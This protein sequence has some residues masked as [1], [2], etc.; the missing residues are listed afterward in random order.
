MIAAPSESQILYSSEEKQNDV[1]EVGPGNLK[2][3]YNAKGKLI[4][5]TNSRTK[6]CSMVLLHFSVLFTEFSNNI[7]VLCILC[8]CLPLCV[9]IA[10]LFCFVLL[11]LNA[12]FN[13]PVYCILISHI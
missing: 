5:Y 1:I 6:V 3:V 2:L 9:Y 13:G 4:R 11:F 10:V 12:K 8:A 7:S